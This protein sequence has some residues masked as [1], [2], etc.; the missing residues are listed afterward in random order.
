[1]T[2]PMTADR[3][4]YYRQYAAVGGMAS[5]NV[6]ELVAEID[7]L[8]TDLAECQEVKRLLHVE[9]CDLREELK[10]QVTHA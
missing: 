4:D 2:D 1:M 6:A 8:S 10:K 3:L 7:R 5:H 9:N